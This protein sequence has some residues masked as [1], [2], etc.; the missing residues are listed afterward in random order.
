MCK[1]KISKGD[2]KCSLQCAPVVSVLV[3]TVLNTRSITAGDLQQCGS[4]GKRQS[5]S[6]DEDQIAV[7]VVRKS[8]S[9]N[10]TCRNT[11]EFFSVCGA[12]FF[13]FLITP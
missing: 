5:Q 2:R 12:F 1:E 13:S 6:H 4:K 8:L 11:T 10:S 7:E 3:S 9:E